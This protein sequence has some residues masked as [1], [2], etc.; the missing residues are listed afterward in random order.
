MVVL[1]HQRTLTSMTKA[2]MPLAANM[3]FNSLIR[4]AFRLVWY[5]VWF[6]KYRGSKNWSA[7]E[8]FPIIV[9]FIALQTRWLDGKLANSTIV[10]NNF[11]LYELDTF[12]SMVHF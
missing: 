3:T 12:F 5:P 4:R 2:T 11:Y 9:L 10:K 7:K 8:I 6:E 1:F